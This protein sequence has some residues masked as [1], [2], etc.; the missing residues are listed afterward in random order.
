M[1]KM[2]LTIRLKLLLAFTV[3]VGLLMITIYATVGSQIKNTSVKNFY[4]GIHRDLNHIDTAFSIFINKGK[5]MALLLAN[6]PAIQSADASIHD[7]TVES[8]PVAAN[9]FPMTRV[10]RNVV[11]LLKLIHTTYPEYVEVYLGTKFGGMSTSG[12]QP[13]PAKYDPRK[14]PWY[15][16]SLE[17]PGTIAVSSAYQSSIGE[18]VVSIISSFDDLNGRPLGVC[19]VDVSLAGLTNILNNAR[20]GK[21][22]YIM[23]LQEDGTILA[24][25]KHEDF[26][27]KNI[28]DVGVPDFS[29]IDDEN[30]SNLEVTMDGTE[31][32][33]QVHV[34]PGVN[35]KLV[36]LM[37]ESEILAS[38]HSSLLVLLAIGA[39][40]MVLFLIFAVAFSH[41]ITTPINRTV[42]ALRNIVQGDGDLTTRLHVSGDNEIRDLAEY[43]NQTIEKI[44][45]S[46]QSIDSAAE[47]LQVSSSTL[48]RS[49]DATVQSVNEINTNIEDVTTQTLAQTETVDETTVSIE[50]VIALIKELN[51]SIETQAASV[52]E[53]SASI[54]EMSANIASVSRTLEKSDTV[55]KDLSFAT[56]D[57]KTV[58]GTTT[59]ITSRLMGESDMLLEASSVIQHIAS[60]TNLLAMN[61]AIEAAHAGESGKGFAVVADE[62]R[63][64]AEE[65]N[66]QGK[67]ITNTLKNLSSEIETL[68]K[69]TLAVEEK[70]TDIFRLADEVRAMSIQINETMTEQEN[71]SREVLST[72][73]NINNVT[74]KVKTDS[75]EMLVNGETVA[76]EVH[77]LNDL[78]QTINNSM[79]RMAENAAKINEAALSVDGISQEN[80]QNINRLA[81][82]VKQFKI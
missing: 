65:S 71:G 40:L 21:T 77:K 56:N 51:Q 13:I 48:V 31:W 39:V 8:E 79:E 4:T 75:N 18:P 27:F 14:R 59:G 73:K 23:M 10:E 66:I 25:P 80:N 64:L 22:G 7:Y 46:I 16:S 44:A 81:D 47:N 68:S 78:A 67:T 42:N 19:G 50:R 72:I 34:I 41:Q 49:M 32:F 61:A 20:I 3:S 60:Q 52:E 45:R 35:W 82:E 38:Y 63:K 2:R 30:V 76:R 53:S 70:F 1:K 24:D 36:A 62:I 74:A 26:I 69:S 54:E 9:S 15:T 5:K 28:K 29:N 43:F 58:L 17:N 57:G 12:D 11:D 37:Q 6:S 55:I 33:A